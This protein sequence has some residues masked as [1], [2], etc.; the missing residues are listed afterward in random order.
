MMTGIFTGSFDPYTI[1]HDDILRRALP[2]FDHIVIGIGVNERKS[3]MQSAEER[4][5]TIKA[6]Y[7]DEPKVEVKTYNDLTIDFARRENASYIIKG[8]RSVK[9]FEY[10]RDQADINRQLSGIETLLLYADPRYSAVSSSMVRELIHF[11][12]DVSRFLP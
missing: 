12:Q 4:M 8:V 7:A 9:D 6:I 2:L 3:Y 5:K 10:E 11:G 1:G